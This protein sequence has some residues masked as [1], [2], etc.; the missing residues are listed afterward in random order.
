MKH[1]LLTQL[2][3][4]EVGKTCKQFLSFPFKGTYD[5][6]SIFFSNLTHSVL[7]LTLCFGFQWQKPS[8][9]VHFPYNVPKN[10]SIK[11]PV[12]GLQPNKLL[13]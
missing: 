8:P 3:K 2:L 4:T 12:F 6:A 13:L 9:Q 1:Q 11:H 5:R 10:Y 7:K